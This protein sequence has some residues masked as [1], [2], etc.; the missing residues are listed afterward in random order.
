MNDFIQHMMVEAVLGGI[1]I[2]AV[3]VIVAWLLWVIGLFDI[4]DNG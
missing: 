1:L 2:L 3:L 4:E